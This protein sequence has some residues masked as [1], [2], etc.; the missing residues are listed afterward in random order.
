MEKGSHVVGVWISVWGN[1]RLG[2]S[3]LEMLSELPPS[4]SIGL[5]SQHL[6]MG[7]QVWLI[8]LGR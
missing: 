4:K 7:T 2:G 1:N 5:A 6:G 8:S 3:G